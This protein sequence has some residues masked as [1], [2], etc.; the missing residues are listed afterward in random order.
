[1]KNFEVI[2]GI[3]VHTVL[4]TN[5]KMFSPAKSSHHSL[6]NVNVNSIDLAL[7]GTMPQP[8]I[9]GIEKGIWLASE[10]NMEINYTNIQ[11]DRKNYF[12]IDLPKGYQITQQ[13]FPIGKNGYV[14]IQ[15]ENNN[16]KKIE[17]ERIH[18]EEDT[19]KQLNENG[20]IY[21][22]YNRVGMPLIE[23]VTKPCISS[24]FEAQQYLKELVKILRFA[25]V[26][27]AKLEDGS[28]RADV[29]ISLRPYGQ[30]VFGN[31]V[32]IKNINSINNVKKAI[33]YEVNR[34][35]KIL[36]NGDKI[37]QETRRFDDTQNITVHMR[38]KTNAVNYRYIHEPN[39]MTISLSD[40]QFI[41]I[42]NKKQLSLLE[43][44]KM[45]ENNGLDQNAI[46]QLINDYEQYK[47][48]KT[49]VSMVNDYSLCFKWLSIEL[50]GL[51]KKDSKSYSDISNDLILKMAKMLNLLLEQEING[52]QAKIILEY[53]YK[54]NKE[55]SV[56]IKELGFEQIKDPKII[57][58]ILL[59]HIDK[60]PDMF[61]SCYD[62][63]ERGEKFFIG[64]LM[65]E[66]N[67]QANPVISYEILKQIMI[68][69][70][71]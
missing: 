59:K 7:P 48:F 1:M 21:L 15:T 53:I 33:D 36:L 31:K 50:I 30:L 6:P 35:M 47:V 17:I 37:E 70:Q 71:Q 43:V 26:S 62:R 61:Q 67:G 20:E 49:L 40:E 56:I 66:T 18:L 27:D 55:P 68:E 12:Y 39:I 24:G 13:Y 9:S 19:A 41:N 5:T 14:E 54:E 45:L 63:P 34:Q 28:L 51:L 64:M 44:V 10:L 42:M 4:N 29:N 46:Q 8:N 25:N 2:I 3:E 69:K 23:I 58:D 38:A 57:R 22:D 65:K 52:K 60:N 16:F 32:E 11:F